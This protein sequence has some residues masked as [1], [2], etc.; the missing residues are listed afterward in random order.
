[1]EPRSRRQ[2]GRPPAAPPNHPAPVPRHSA[3]LVRPARHIRVHPL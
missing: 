3:L 2:R 1:M